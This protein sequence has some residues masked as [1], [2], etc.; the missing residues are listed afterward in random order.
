MLKK[1][2]N[3]HAKVEVK[4]PRGPQ[5]HRKNYRQLINTERGDTDISQEEHTNWLSNS[6]KIYI[7][8]TLYRLSMLCLR[9]YVHTYMNVTRVN[10]RRGYEFEKDSI[11]EYEK[12]WRDER[13]GGN[14]IFIL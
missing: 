4:K 8:V 2:N 6:I 13:E 3:G 9:T 5:P 11:G 12:I 7:Q 14:G 10:E 1:D